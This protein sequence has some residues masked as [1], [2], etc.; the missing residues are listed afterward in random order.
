MPQ[1]PLIF[2]IWS[3]TP[4]DPVWSEKKRIIFVTPFLGVQIYA[5]SDLDYA[6]SAKVVKVVKS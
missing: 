1:I 3:G 6:K 2:T 5:V 4:F